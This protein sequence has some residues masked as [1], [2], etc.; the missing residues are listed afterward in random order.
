MSSAVQ[1][2]HDEV[3]QLILSGYAAQVVSTF[4]NLSV[5]EHLADGPL[6]AKQLAAQASSDPDMTYRLLR[7]GVGLGLL[8]YDNTTEAF[9]PT[10][11]LGILHPD[12]AFTLKHFA[13]A[14]T[15]SAFWQTAQRLTD[16]VRRGR[17]YVEETLG[18]DLWE[19]LGRHNDE[20]WMFRTA[21]TDISAPVVR[22]AVEA[23]DAAEKGFVVDVGG[24]S[25][26]FVG[27]LL[28][29]NRQLTGAVFDL[30]QAMPG[31]AEHAEALG[32]PD[33]LSGIAGDFFESAP[34]GD[35]YLLKFI[36]H[37]WSDESCIKILSNIRR[38]MKP[39]ARLFVVEMV[40]PERDVPRDAALMD[41]VMLFS[42]TGQERELAEYEKLLNAA[43]LRIA[44]T[45][46]LR[47]PYQLIEA[48]PR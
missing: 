27:E 37:D 12:S 34:A 18:G 42:L 11:R 7:A 13:Q 14:A 3:L 21:M 22:E 32:I 43:D 48:R 36:L 17:N 5:A 24:A 16:S 31:V 41:I 28:E 25:G 47:K 23:I 9:A 44:K 19:Y 20:A 8:E 40:I 39:G 29:R 33:R 35:Y 46:A 4:A 6:T 30:P 1:D 38:A 15:G 26:T 45:T 2:E 10:A